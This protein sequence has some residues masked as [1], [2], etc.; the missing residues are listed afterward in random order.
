MTTKVGSVTF[1]LCVPLH[2]NNNNNDSMLC[3]IMA[4]S[5]YYQYVL[6]ENHL[7]HL[8]VP[9]RNIYSQPGMYNKESVFIFQQQF[10]I[11]FW[12]QTQKQTI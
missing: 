3:S 2:N 6:P 11:K 1:V 12:I 10:R 7:T 4:Y 5:I 8:H 9:T